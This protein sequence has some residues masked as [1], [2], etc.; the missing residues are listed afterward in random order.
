MRRGCGVSGVC[1][2]PVVPL[3]YHLVEK[4]GVSPTGFRERC[5]PKEIVEMSKHLKLKFAAALLLQLAL[6]LGVLAQVDRAP[7]GSVTV[8]SNVAR[9]TCASTP[10][11][12]A[13]CNSNAAAN[14][15]FKCLDISTISFGTHRSRKPAGET[16][17]FSTRW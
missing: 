15:S 1:R 6:A 3:I 4:N 9:S 5:V 12:S 10:R 13:N 14:L 16:P 11:A 8:P 2:S 7:L 17:F